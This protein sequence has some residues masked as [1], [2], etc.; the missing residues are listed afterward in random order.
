MVLWLTAALS[1]VGIAVANN[2]RGETQRTETNL[3][4]VRSYFAARGAIEQA[5][6]HMLWGRQYFGDNG[7]PMYY[8]NGNPSMNL[9]LPSAEV[10][11]D[12]VPETAKLSVNASR[13]A[14]ILRLLMALG[15][16][17]DSAN[18][19]AAAIVDWRSPIDQMH[20]SFF[21]PYYLSQSPSFLARHASFQ[22]NEELLSIKGMTPELYY[23]SS[24][25]SR[26]AGLRDCLSVY[27]TAGA[28]DVNTA[29]A[30]TLVAVGLAPADAATLVR[31]RAAHPILDG[32]ELGQL[33]QSLGPEGGR[34]RIGGLTM[35][36][37][38][39]TARL[40]QPDGRLSDLRRTVGAFVKFYFP[41][42]KGTKQPG[43][44]VLRWYDRV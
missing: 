8:V 13:P 25:D 23:G 43:F 39:A 4:D 15:V 9:S 17:E 38:R 22:E 12:I 30:A 7:M 5:A 24:L 19:L 16:P 26:R 35:F 44:D 18:D 40:R 2:V 20:P 29:Q 11:V 37:L 41:G 1:A 32:K 27:G 42:D 31:S 21:D 3:D 34:L 28:V 10:H 33:V 36:T 6:L 14:D